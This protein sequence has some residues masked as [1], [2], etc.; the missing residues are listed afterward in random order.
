MLQDILADE[1]QEACAGGAS[2]PS[3]VGSNPFAS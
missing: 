1:D 2:A 3:S